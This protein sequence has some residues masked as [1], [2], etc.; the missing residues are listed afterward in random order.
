MEV[1]VNGR[2]REVP[3]DSTVADLVA[4]LGFGNKQVVVEHNGEA[5]ERARFAEI[6]LGPRDVVEVVR[7]VQGGAGASVGLH[8]EAT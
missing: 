3:A 1:L 5:V 4:A 6:V 8:R 2:Q 7:P